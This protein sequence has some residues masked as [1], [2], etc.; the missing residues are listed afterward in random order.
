VIVFKETMSPMRI[1]GVT[2]VVLGV[3]LLGFGDSSKPSE[4]EVR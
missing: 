1:A 2:T 4:G 3:A